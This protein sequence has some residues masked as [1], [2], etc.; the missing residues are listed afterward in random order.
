MGG[1]QSFVGHP[2]TRHFRRKCL[3]PFFT[4]NKKIEVEVHP[5]NMWCQPW[6]TIIVEPAVVNALGETLEYGILDE[7][8]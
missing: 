3:S 4:Q 8:S 6:C 1:Q 2:A 5:K 7:F